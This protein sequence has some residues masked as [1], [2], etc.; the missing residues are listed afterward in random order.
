MTLETRAETMLRRPQIDDHGPGNT[1]GHPAPKKIAAGL[2]KPRPMDWRKL[3][4]AAPPPRDWAI[5]GWVGMGHVTM[6]A[7]NGGIGKTL[8]GQTIG[9]ALALKRDYIG[10]V[11]KQHTTMLWACEDD[12]DELWRRQEAIAA[13]F[14]TGLA[15]FAERFIIVPRLGCDNTPPTRTRNPGLVPGFFN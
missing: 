11:G 1:G 7:G 4:N 10:A 8:L 9:S 15:D 14:G 5:D 12:H 2:P 3:S 6:L 13:H